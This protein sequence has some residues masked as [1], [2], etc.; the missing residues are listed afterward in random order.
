MATNHLDQ[1]D[2]IAIGKRHEKTIVELLNKHRPV[3]CHTV[4]DKWSESTQTEDMLLKIDAW[5][6]SGLNPTKRSVQIKYRETGGDLGIAMVRPYT[7]FNSFKRDFENGNVSW[8]RDF[9]NHVDLYVCLMGDT[10][11]VVEG[12]RIRKACN[13]MLD[14]FVVYGGFHG[15][16]GFAWPSYKGAELRLVTDRGN[17]YSEGQQKIICYLTT[18]VIK[19]CGGYVAKA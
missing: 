10:L 3:V 1:K 8:D 6:T 9:I 15:Y 5:A 17:G 18:D 4:Y 16:R 7:D 19:L 13:L 14:K 11:S 2:R 12:E